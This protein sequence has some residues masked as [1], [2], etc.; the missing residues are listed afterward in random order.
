MVRALKRLS[1]KP[2]CIGQY[3]IKTRIDLFPRTEATFS[4]HLK[5]QLLGEHLHCLYKLET[6]KFHDEGEGCTAFLTPKTV[7][8][9]LIWTDRK[10]RGLLIM[11]RTQT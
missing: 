4:G 1:V 2:L 8:K 3:I 9:L 6:L 11:K 5:A 10:G 7:K